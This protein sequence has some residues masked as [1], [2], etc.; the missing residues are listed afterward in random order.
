PR[1]R[2]QDAPERDSDKLYTDV[3][4]GCHNVRAF[5][6]HTLNIHFKGFSEVMHSPFI[7]E[8]EDGSERYIHAAIFMADDPDGSKN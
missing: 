3:N 6:E 2:A 4:E 1:I 5:Y 8:M 7:V